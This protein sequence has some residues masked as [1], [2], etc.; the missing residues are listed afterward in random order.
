M[1]AL[2]RVI[3]GHM[4][5]SD[6]FTGFLTGFPVMVV[7]GPIAVLLMESGLE[8]GLRGAYPAALGVTAADLC[9]SVMA[10]ATGMAAVEALAPVQEWLSL[11]AVVLLVLVA[12]RLAGAAVR[13]LGPG[14]VVAVPGGAGVGSTDREAG[15]PSIDSRALALA[16]SFFGITA[17]NPVTVAVFAAIVLS[18]AGG[19][20]TPGWV[21]GMVLASL[22]V[23]LGFV[24]VGQVLG[25]LLGRE[26]V[27]RL[28]LVAA[29]LIVAMALHLALG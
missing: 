2:C 4:T 3:L 19:V 27:A 29:A 23:N 7:V 15:R 1:P 20:G 28:K 6:L 14:R 25:A 24:A 17:L 22:V 13:D 12:V 18:G 21:V 26:S 9:F 8:K 11:G 10:A 5:G 16:G